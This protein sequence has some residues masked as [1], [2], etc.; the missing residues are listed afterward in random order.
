MRTKYTKKYTLKPLACAMAAVLLGLMGGCG[1]GG[2]SP[3]PVAATPPPVQ[4]VPAVP[5]PAPVTQFTVGGTVEGLGQGAVLT[6]SNGSDKLAVSANGPFG[7]AGKLEAGA[8]FNIGATAPDGYSCRVTDGAGV[9][10]GANISKSVVA[11]AP[12]VL[13]GL[14][15]VLQLPTALAGDANG[16]LY[17]LD[18]GPSSILKLSANGAVG[19]LAGAGDPGYADSAGTAA[20][21]WFRGGD[22]VADAQGNLIVADGCNGAIRKVTSEGVVSTLAG[23]GTDACKGIPAPPGGR[24]ADG[25]GSAARFEQPRKMVSDGAGGVIVLD[26]V[27]FTR[28][29]RI[30]A[31]GAVTTQ[32]WTDPNPYAFYS[33]VFNTIARRSDGVLVFSD[34]EHRLWKDVDGTLVLL[35][36]GPRTSSMADGT[37]AAAR[38]RA[39]ADM[40]AGPNGELYVADQNTVRKVTAAGVVTTLAGD[41]ARA[42]FADGS[43]TAARFGGIAA[44]SF[45]GA[46]LVVIDADAGVLRRVGLDGSVS[47]VAATPVVRGNVDGNGAAAR[48]NGIWTLSADADG[49]LYFVDRATHVLRKASPDGSVTT[50]GGTPGVAG[51]ADGPIASALF[52]SPHTIA[53]GRDGL[54]WVAQNKGLRKIQNGSVTTLAPNV[55]PIDLTVDGDGNAIVN[56][57]M[58]IL[59]ITPAGEST[60]LVTPGQIAALAGNPALDP[61]ALAPVVDAAGNLYLADY[62]TAAVYKRSKT[63][64]LTVHAGTPLRH[65]D[66]D[67]PAGTGSLNFD[68]NV[69]MTIDD[70]GFL[71]LSIEGGVRMISPTGVLSSPHLGWGKATIAALAHA[72]G[73]LYGMTRHALLQ[74]WLP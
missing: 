17:V 22:V 67:G 20:R 69:Y 59:R 70:K 56:D 21:F 44:I 32:A 1:G 31:A 24:S 51:T 60:V 29:R 45:D 9:M 26:D 33:T 10:P 66:V 39:I 72:K 65:G 35:A 30:S 12:L 7:F 42:G 71:Y 8:G 68:S 58:D 2:A 61:V 46:G 23:N 18:R 19:V 11:C 52:T 63:G 27:N 43:G 3:G 55:Y 37:G 38:F 50:I 62:V 49:N 47:G 4:P 36:G 13:A 53:A 5:V 15:N 48:I 34:Q 54:L 25:L 74:T 41:P 57:G 28:V 64:E 40:V 16:N 6:L 14:R 73:K